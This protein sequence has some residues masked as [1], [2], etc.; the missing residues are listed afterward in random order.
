MARRKRQSGG[1]GDPPWLITFSD[2]MTLLLTFFVLLLSMSVI[3]ERAKLEVLGSVS[4]SFGSK[5]SLFNPAS[6][7]EN[8][9]LIEPGRMEGRTED[10]APMR[11]MLFEDVN[12]DLDFQEN[13]Y[14]QIL[15]INDQ[16]LFIPGGT[17]LSETGLA[18]LDRVVPYLQRIEYPLLV[19]GHT[20]M[21]RDEESEYAVDLHG[22]G[23]D[24]TWPL[25]FHRAL[26][27]YRHFVVRGIN[28]ARLS[29]EA[30]GQFHPRYSN[31]TPAGR[32]KNR[33]VDLV[34]DKRNKSWIEKMEALREKDPA[35][36]NE[37][38]YKGFRFD[39]TVPG[40]T[41]PQRT[42]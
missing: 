41:Q 20:A 7:E 24:S 40:S 33:R 31:N 9:R 21:R 1:G 23:V 25:S 22:T 2:L 19:A 42:P 10:L 8:L 39:L 30:F 28:P 26:A 3:D 29:L 37:T 13:K 12:N 4:R 5:A 32:Q 38:Y 14:V 16:V 34:L 6:R 27:V 35:T 15:S 11:D 17:R 36:V 18:L